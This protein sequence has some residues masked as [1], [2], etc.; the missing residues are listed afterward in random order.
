[1][2]APG[3]VI[4]RYELVCPIGE[5]GMAHVWAARQ[6]GGHGFE[7]I[8][9]VKLVHS[10][11][12][13]NGAFR[14]MF[15][16]EASIV[17]PIQH[18]NV[19]Q[20]FDLGESGPLLYLVME[21]VDGESLFGL[22]TPQRTVPLSI[23]LRIAADACAGLHAVHSLA[24]AS[25]RS[26]NVVHRDV[27]PQNILLGSNGDVK[28]IDFGIAHARD[29]AAPTTDV[30]T[31]KG[32][33]RYMAPEQVRHETLGPH[34]DVFGIG[35][36]LFR[37]IA[38][39]APYA[40]ADELT[41]IQALSAGFPAL[42]ALPPDVPRHVAAVV[43]RAIAP[44]VEDRFRTAKE[45][46]ET[47]ESLIASVPRAD[48][49]SWVEAN[50]TD[51]T[52][53]RRARLASHTAFSSASAIPSLGF[54][55]AS[56]HAA[57]PAP[58]GERNESSIGQA[59][60]FMDVGALV[61]QA[62]GEAPPPPDENA[63]ARAHRT[64]H[65]ESAQ[66][67]PEDGQPVPSPKAGARAKEGS[68]GRALK[69]AI[70]AIVIVVLVS[71]FLLLLPIIVRDRA[72]ASARAAGIDIEIERVGVGFGGVTL[73][74][75]T[76]KAI[77]TP[78]M[79]ATVQEVHLAGISGKDARLLGVDARLEG[80]LDDLE[81]GIASLVADNRARLA[82]TPSSPQHLSVV[83]ARLD[84]KGPHGE[85][86]L[87]GDIGLELDS[88]GAEVEDARGSV[89]RFE[90]TTQTTTYGPWSSAFERNPTN[91]RVRVMFD[92]P[93]PDGPSALV[94]WGKAIPTELT[95]KVPRSPFK[96]LGI[97]P[98]EL[99][100]P[101][102]DSTDVEV[103]IHGKLAQSARSEV[104]G[105]A[106]LWGV[107]PKGMSGR[108][109]VHVEGGASSTEGKPYQLEK[110]TVTVGPFVA[111]VSGTVT[112]HERGFR[113]DALFKTLPM[114]CE[115]LVRMEAQSMGTFAAT[116]QALGQTT[117]AL[118]VTGSVNASGV[119]KYDTAAPEDAGVTWLAKETCGVSI[120]GM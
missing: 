26:R 114:P 14:R 92:P 97:K 82:G 45:L 79:T 108:L 63:A 8:V 4:D 27:S 1:V 3:Q 16:D 112:P 69:L 9:A 85:R 24:D 31:V 119:V 118:R 61:A 41:T 53:E 32:K 19:A 33:V 13:E 30:G 83:G 15:L 44:R 54:A 81:L 91:A 7:K 65:G 60:S 99:G 35:A 2:L 74:G 120:F 100:I 36:T 57:K 96:N 67:R 42:Q 84:W 78:G 22:T 6:R 38:G 111:G 88:R 28:L 34:T 105:E 93:V 68:S 40:A 48:L 5:G 25:G 70:L 110:T 86:L 106:S 66:T 18:R 46:G 72:I 64:T 95:I 11:L 20:V 21:Y 37:M 58:T 43:H 89:G 107:R 113:L 90:L 62:R 115:R 104:T 103:K 117:G 109:D 98:S 17:A 73:R 59:P 29:R 51:E 76:A 94:V 39:H 50:V 77:R 71:G 80:A 52:R 87:A 49:G 23:A 56:V 102:D 55:A 75:V 116:L 12:A 47:L 101:A 10:R